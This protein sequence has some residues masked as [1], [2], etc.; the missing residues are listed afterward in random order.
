MKL[1][2]NPVYT[3]LLYNSL[4][5]DVA[6]LNKKITE[7]EARIKELETDKDFMDSLFKIATELV[8]KG[9]NITP[10]FL[11]KKLLIDLPRAENIIRKLQDNHI[12]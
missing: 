2:S 10:I 6:L 11:Q 9:D 7:L 3:S 12:L 4:M 1:P 8:K 5:T